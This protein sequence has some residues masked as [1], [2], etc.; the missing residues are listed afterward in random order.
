MATEVNQNGRLTKYSKNVV[1]IAFVGIYVL[2]NLPLIRI[3][4]LHD[5][6]TIIAIIGHSPEQFLF[7]ALLFPGAI[8]LTYKV[9]TVTTGL[10]DQ[11]PEVCRTAFWQWLI[12]KRLILVTSLL[13]GLGVSALNRVDTTLDF[14]QRIPADAR[15]A[16]ELNK[17]IIIALSRAHS[18]QARDTLLA[19]QQFKQNLEMLRAIYLDPDNTD[20]LMGLFEFIELG[21]VGFT[22]A[23]AMW[24]LYL[25]LKLLGFARQL[26]DPEYGELLTADIR[27]TIPY[28]VVLT[29]IYLF[30]PPLRSYNMFEI[31]QVI[32]YSSLNPVNIYGV[33][34]VAAITMIW[35]HYSRLG[36]NLISTITAVLSFL[37][38]GALMGLAGFSPESLVDYVGSGMGA[39]NLIFLVFI[40]IIFYIF[41]AEIFRQVTGPSKLSAASGDED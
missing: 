19:D 38:S 31:R 32:P 33:V 15:T 22:V 41:G 24:M 7:L 28:G 39:A 8:F 37:A 3:L 30:W 23:L 1:G 20:Q 34:A 5:V 2:I 29:I 4:T 14:Y 16:A 40:L 11:Y 13:I 6:D 26:D 10:Q 12:N 21:A 9:V 17:Q 18:P 36:K 25:N 35:L 27:K